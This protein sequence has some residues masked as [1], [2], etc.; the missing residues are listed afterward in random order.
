MIG[1]LYNDAEADDTDNE[2]AVTFLKST[3]G[4]NE[5]NKTT[6][7]QSSVDDHAKN[8]LKQNKTLNDKK[9]PLNKNNKKKEQLH[10]M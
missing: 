9:T 6:E 5:S 3:K 4:N 2:N 8:I 1:T 7:S 10:L